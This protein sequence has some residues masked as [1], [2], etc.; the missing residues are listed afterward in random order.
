MARTTTPAPIEPEEQLTMPTT[1]VDTVQDDDDGIEI[2][3]IAPEELAEGA[4]EKYYESV[5]RRKRSIARVR[6]MT[7]KSGDEARADAA[8]MTINGRDYTEYFTDKNLQSRVEQPLRRLK[9][10]TRFKVTVKVLGG[11][12]SGQAD[13]ICHGISRTLEL[14][15]GNFRKKLKKA[16]FLTR[17]SRRVERKKPGLKK[18]RKG[19]RWA[20]R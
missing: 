19:P 15:D 1:F 3:P 9:S 12:I 6:L 14:F 10:L 13:A 17:D 11:G 2:A 16:G 20:K 7:R 8:L 5:G 4:K 18:A